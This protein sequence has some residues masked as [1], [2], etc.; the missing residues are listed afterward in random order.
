MA[1]Y[2]HVRDKAELL[3]LIGERVLETIEIPT[4]SGDWRKQLRDVHRA[5]L[6]PLLDHPNA[7]EL[8]IGRA[9]FGAAGITRFERILAI[10]RDAGFGPSAAFDAYQ[11]LYL[12]QLGFMATARR[13]PEFRAIQVEGAAYL[14]S[15]DPTSFPAIAEI[16][17]V[18]GARSLEEQHDVGLDVVIE[19]IQAALPG[20][21]T[22]RARP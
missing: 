16:A 3:D 19:G 6:G 4:P 7:I 9:R 8:M 2:W 18:I 10:L 5:M 1:V 15:L 12:F 21:R 20:G 13:T 17:P 22:R 14:R 11:S